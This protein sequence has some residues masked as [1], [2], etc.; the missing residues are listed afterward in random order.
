[1]RIFVKYD[2]GEPRPIQK[3]KRTIFATTRSVNKREKG[4]ITT[5]P[6][7]R[8]FYQTY[9]AERSLFFPPKVLCKL[10]LSECVVCT[11]VPCDKLGWWF[12]CPTSSWNKKCGN[13]DPK[14]KE[15]RLS[16]SS[17]FFDNVQSKRKTITKLKKIWLILCQTNMFW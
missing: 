14:W 8:F 1:M 17:F 4:Q 6:Y 16:T 9:Q 13:H 3:H 5:N 12:P 7:H 15:I 2:P 10:F 11:K